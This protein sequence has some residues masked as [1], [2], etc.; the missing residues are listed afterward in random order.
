MTRDQ[1]R[2][3]S[4]SRSFYRQVQAAS[5]G[6]ILAQAVTLL[7]VPVITRFYEPENFG[8]YAL[9]MILPNIVIP[10][11][12]GKFDVA[13]PVPR[14][15]AAAR[16]L[17]G[18]GVKCI[19]GI[20]PFLAVLAVIFRLFRTDQQA[21]EPVFFTTLVP[22]YAALAASLVLMQFLLVRTGDFFRLGLVRLILATTTSLSSIAFALLGLE[23]EGL[24]L[25]ACTGQFTA[26]LLISFWNK[27]W[28]QFSLIKWSNRTTFVLWR[29]RSFPA[30]NATTG[31]FNSMMLVVPFIG[32][33]T[34]FDDQVLG[35]FELGSRI[36]AA[37]IMLAASIIGSVNLRKVAELVSNSGR[38]DQHV[39]KIM[40]RMWAIALPPMIFI[41]LFGPD[42]VALIFGEAWRPAGAYLQFLAP[43]F[44]AQF[45]AAP[46]STTIAAT[47]NNKLGGFWNIGALATLCGT[48]LIVGPIGDTSAFFFWIGITRFVNYLAYQLL[49]LYCARNP[50]R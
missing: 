14:S 41:L 33:A 24:I 50:V 21:F 29:F 18:L 32:I 20:T 48:I 19:I 44:A 36:A 22:T 30:V 16:E 27:R 28:L 45:V 12:A 1:S 38:P 46:L 17:L 8:V 7:S 10:N 26:L 11:L 6:T 25:G 42:F 4:S 49:I 2:P 43:A 35:W 34:Y 39:F 9:F 5:F 31:I 15:D 3:P 13:I 23:T 37:P 47:R 40:L